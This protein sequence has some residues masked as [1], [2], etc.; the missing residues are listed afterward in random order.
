MLPRLRRAEY[1]GGYRIWL[2]F[3]DGVQGE[4]NLERELWGEM[5]APLRDEALFRRFV[6]DP[7]LETIVW[8]NGADLAPEFLYKELCPGYELKGVSR[9]GTA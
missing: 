5:F 6:L 3:A 2:E 7:E 8:P 1:R 4:V 9:G